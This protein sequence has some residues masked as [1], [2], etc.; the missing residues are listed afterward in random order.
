MAVGDQRNDDEFDHIV[1]ANHLVSHYIAQALQYADGGFQVCA[2]VLPNL[3]LRSLHSRIPVHV[4]L[5]LN[6]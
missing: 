4:A 5:F 6:G 1:T 3:V 2:R